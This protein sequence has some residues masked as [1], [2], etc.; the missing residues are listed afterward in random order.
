M[1]HL[2][3]CLINQEF[4]FYLDILYKYH[5]DYF[6]VVLYKSLN[7]I[8]NIKDVKVLEKNNNK[9]LLSVDTN[10]TTV[11]KV[12]NEYSKVCE[13][14]DVNVLE[15]SIDNVIVKLYEEYDL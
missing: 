12:I 2:N 7:N 4:S 3:S 15:S 5:Y 8:P 1:F 9:V 10:T 14:L 6:Y 13:I 11:S